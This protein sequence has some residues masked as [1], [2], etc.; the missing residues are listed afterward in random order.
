M[1]QVGVVASI[2]LGPLLG[3]AINWV[4]FYGRTGLARR[5]RGLLAASVCLGLIASA[6]MHATL[7]LS[8]L[9]LACGL[10]ATAAAGAALGDAV[11]G[12]ISDV[13]SATVFLA[14]VAAIPTIHEPYAW[15]TGL[16]GAALTGAIL[17][18]VRSGF[19]AL[20]GHDGLGAGDIGLASACGAWA[21][22]W[23]IGP[24][25]LASV[26]ITVAFST[27]N[28]SRADPKLA[29]GPGLVIGFAAAFAFSLAER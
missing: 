21:G 18:S 26:V 10:A 16:G 1:G 5:T 22:L 6:L 11:D 17:V 4:G 13:Q 28:R 7:G 3:G 24:A 8:H 14:G 25:L 2:M 27:M 23:Y 15:L 19:K 29:F 12:L 20:K 9:T